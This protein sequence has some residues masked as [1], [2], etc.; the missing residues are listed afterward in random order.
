V[1]EFDARFDNLLNQIPKDLCPP[2]AVILL[3]YLNSFEGQFGFILK[4][5]MPENLAKAKEYTVQIEEHLIS[6]KIEPFQFPRA[7][8]NLRRRCQPTMYRIQVTLLAQKF[9]QMNAQFVQSQNQIMNR[10]TNLER[11]HS[12]PRPQF[13]R[14]QEGKH[15]L[16]TK[17]TTRSEGT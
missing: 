17:A 7:R 5:K 12:A 16:E 6:S 11:Q 8:K 9:D 15:R 4:E 13:I 10:L 2:E 1:K 14:Q 3:L